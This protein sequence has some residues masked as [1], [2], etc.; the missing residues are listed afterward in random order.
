MSVFIIVEICRN[1][2]TKNQN[3]PS[4]TK[5]GDFLDKIYEIEKKKKK[6]YNICIYSYTAVNVI[7][8]KTQSII[9]N[10]NKINLILLI[11]AN[12]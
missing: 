11:E 2:N 3:M 8:V 1:V 12:L 5:K 4:Q 9:S 10:K 6:V 7:I